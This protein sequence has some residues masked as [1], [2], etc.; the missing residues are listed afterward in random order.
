MRKRAHSQCFD[1]ECSDGEESGKPRRYPF[2]F[3]PF[4]MFSEFEY[5]KRHLRHKG[6]APSIFDKFGHVTAQK[7]KRINREVEKF[8]SIA[9]VNIGECYIANCSLC[10]PI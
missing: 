7:I 2:S 6:P 8:V 9:K 5:R 4:Q 10:P 3:A 1:G